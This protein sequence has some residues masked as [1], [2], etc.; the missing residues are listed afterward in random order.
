MTSLDHQPRKP[1]QEWLSRKEAAHYLAERGCPL[2]EKTLRNYASNSNALGGPPFVRM[3]WN[4]VRYRP[5][6]LDVWLKS[7]MIEVE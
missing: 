2:T 5:K 7:R 1:E 4:M 6:A 3:G